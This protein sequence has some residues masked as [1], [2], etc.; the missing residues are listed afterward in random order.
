MKVI[1]KEGDEA[2]DLLMADIKL[3]IKQAV[4]ELI[5]E[6]KE[7]EDKTEEEEWCG[8]ERAREILGVGKTKMQELRDHSPQNGI[9]IR[10]PSPRR[11]RYHVPSLHR[12]LR[13]SN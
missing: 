3:S 13:S 7:G 9:I 8:S 4:R 1:L 10:K 6:V 12:W 2:Y 11:I 5:H